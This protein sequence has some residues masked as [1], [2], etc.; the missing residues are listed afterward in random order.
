MPVID[1]GTGERSE[2]ES[3]EL[4]VALHGVDQEI[5]EARDG[6]PP[7]LRVLFKSGETVVSYSVPIGTAEA[8]DRIAPFTTG[9]PS[10]FTE[11]V[12]ADF[13]TSNGVEG[14]YT[15]RTW[16]DYIQEFYAPVGT[17][18]GTLADLRQTNKGDYMWFT[19]KSREGFTSSFPAPVPEGFEV[20]K[21][22]TP[23]EDFIGGTFKDKNNKIK[24]SF[25]PGKGPFVYLVQLGLD[26]GRFLDELGNAPALAPGHF[27]NDLKP[28]LPYMEIGGEF[29]PKGNWCY[30]QNLNDITPELMDATRR[31]GLKTI[32][33]TVYDDEKYGLSVKRGDYF[34]ELT[35]VVVDD[36]GKESA[37]FEREKLVFLEEWD[38]LTST[39]F[40]KPDARFMVGGKFTPDGLTVA[41]TVLIPVLNRWPDG[42]LVK[43]ED[44]SP[45][46]HVP[47]TQD[48]WN[49]NAVVAANWTA[50]ALRE[51]PEE[52]RF[53]INLSDPSGGWV[54]QWAEAVMDEVWAGSGFT[55]DLG[56]VL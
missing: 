53:K 31:H 5:I 16:G 45:K 50:K 39:L 40:A 24:K 23:E 37:E 26:W 9:K 6:R 51:L 38:K 11:K 36:S 35:Q 42:I 20:R 33:W 22:Q 56:E 54:V 30:F 34:F 52:E 28:I 1:A 47:P 32:Q 3:G 17:H 27:T 43:K 8:L 13:I 49:I 2:R 21:G 41:K 44:G 7:A 12:L 18:I 4:V 15:V 14:P 25:T 19:L 46:V 10:G 48:T 55:E 29:P